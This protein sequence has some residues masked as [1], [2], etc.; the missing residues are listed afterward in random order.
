MP[1][2]R[3]HAPDARAPAPPGP[4]RAA[5][6]PVPA[7]AALPRADAPLPYGRARSEPA[8]GLRDESAAVAPPR[9]PPP[10]GRGAAPRIVGERHG[11][12]RSVPAAW[13]W[14]A[15]RHAD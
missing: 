14:L 7:R 1:G 5:T 11:A 15:R 13:R 2:A 3:A 12:G 4:R 9:V 6:A 8:Q 10:A